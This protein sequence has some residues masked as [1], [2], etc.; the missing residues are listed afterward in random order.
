M[1]LF[2]DTSDNDTTRIALVGQKT[3]EHYW[4]SKFNQSEFLVS[5]IKKFLKKNKTEFNKLKKI[6][7]VVGPGHFSRVR[8]GVATANALGY[9]LKIP[10]VGI[11]NPVL[12]IQE[13]KKEKGDK[14]VLVYYDKAPNIT[15]PKKK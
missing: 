6:A 8:T 7:V 4:V 5:E 3:A 13:L 9:A 12:N 14:M 1:L 10:V 11:K 15:K 2:L